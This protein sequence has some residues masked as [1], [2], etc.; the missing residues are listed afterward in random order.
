MGQTN[1]YLQYL[2]LELGL[3]PVAIYQ[4]SAANAGGSIPLRLADSICRSACHALYLLRASIFG[5]SLAGSTEPGVSLCGG[6][7]CSSDRLGHCRFL[8]PGVPFSEQVQY[9]HLLSVLS[10]L[11]YTPRYWRGAVRS[12]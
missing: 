8:R 9:L 6:S 11:L 7:L 2:L 1:C 5:R 10:Q 4:C 3:F 12:C